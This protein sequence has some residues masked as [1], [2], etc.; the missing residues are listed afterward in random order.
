MH[1]TKHK[2]RNPKKKNSKKTFLFTKFQTRV[3]ALVLTS[4]QATRYKQGKHKQKKITFSQGV[5]LSSEKKIDFH[6]Q[7]HSLSCEHA[8]YRIGEREREREGRTSHLQFL[9]FHT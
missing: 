3:C 9:P 8:L 4:P 1:K 2:K 7:Q 5:N 6:H